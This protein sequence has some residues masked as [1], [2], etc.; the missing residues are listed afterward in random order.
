MF[1]C[2]Y[3]IVCVCVFMYACMYVCVYVCMYVCDELLNV[4]CRN[5][6]I[7]SALNIVMMSYHPSDEMA[8]NYFLSTILQFILKMKL[9]YDVP[10]TLLLQHRTD[11]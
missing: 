9:I 10:Y 5:D 4:H 6:G 1:V 8:G 7:I 3:I 2:I 11:N